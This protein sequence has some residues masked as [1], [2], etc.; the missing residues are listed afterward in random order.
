MHFIR[1]A[2]AGS[3]GLL[4]LVARQH[5]LL[6]RRPSDRVIHALLRLAPA[7]IEDG[8]RPQKPWPRTEPRARHRV[9]QG[10]QSLWRQFA[11]GFL[12]VLD[13]LARFNCRRLLGP[14]PRISGLALD[15]ARP[16]AGT[17]LHLRS[18]CFSRAESELCVLASQ[19]LVRRIPDKQTIIA[20]VAA[21]VRDRNNNRAVA[22]WRF[23]TDDARIKLKSS[24]P[25]I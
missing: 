5:Q 2:L 24:Y 11:R 4:A 21:W 1:L 12:D 22:E 7:A 3:L 19:C 14:S 9:L 17:A 25:S 15:R 6:Q 20:E 8:G 23:T 18:T 16:L 13:D 10:L